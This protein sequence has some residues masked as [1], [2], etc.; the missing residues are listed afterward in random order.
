MRLHVK[1]LTTQQIANY[2]S[3][4][5]HRGQPGHIGRITDGVLADMTAWQN[6]PWAIICPVLLIEVP[7]IEVPDTHV[8][9]SRTT[10]LT[11]ASPSDSLSSSQ[12]SQYESM[13]SPSVG[14][15]VEVGVRL[16]RC[17]AQ[18]PHPKQVHSPKIGRYSNLGTEVRRGSDRP[19]AAGATGQPGLRGTRS[20]PAEDRGHRR[21]SVEGGDAGLVAATP[22]VFAAAD[23]GAGV[24]D[25]RGR[26]R[27]AGRA[28]C[29]WHPCEYRRETRA[30]VAKRLH[31]PVLDWMIQLRNLETLRRLE[32]L[33]RDR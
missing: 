18:R 17:V 27:P 24:A 14:P 16:V 6:R 11:H 22:R 33:A 1:G 32:R 23:R 25:G 31:N 13:S 9:L 28:G 8:A 3:R 19:R 12:L 26:H 2:P 20:A 5:R 10:K 4:W 7:V 30:G 29:R 15:F 21:S